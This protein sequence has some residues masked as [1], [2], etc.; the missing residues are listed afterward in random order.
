[1]KPLDRAIFILEQNLAMM[2]ANREEMKARLVATEASLGKGTA[3]NKS[4]PKLRMAW[5]K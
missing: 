2:K 4:I 1:L 3:R 5:E